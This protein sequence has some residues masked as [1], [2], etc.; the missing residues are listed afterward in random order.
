M[1]NDHYPSGSVRELLKTDLVKP[2]THTVLKDRLERNKTIAP[3]FFDTKTFDILSSVCMRLIPQEDRSEKIDLPGLLDEQLSVGTGKGWRFNQLPPDKILYIRGLNGIN[4][5]CELMYNKTFDLLAEEEQ[6]AV[7][8]GIQSGKPKSKIWE[9][10]PGLFFQEL[11]TSLTELYYSYPLAKEE[12]GE[13]AFADGKGWQKIGLNE[14]EAHEPL[15]VT[16]Q[17]NDK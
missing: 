6:D 17:E 13:V 10:M 3:V 14:H 8:S 16:N 7:L 15:P 9:Q 1:K 11:L 12:I 5:T 4:E 2:L